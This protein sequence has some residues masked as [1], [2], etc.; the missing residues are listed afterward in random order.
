MRIITQTAGAVA[1]ILTLTVGSAPAADLPR[2]P[3]PVVPSPIAPVR[4]YDWTGPYAGANLGYQW[5]SAA[6]SGA[7][8]SG[9][10]GGFQG[11]YNWQL[12]QFVL[13]VESDLQASAADDLFAAWRFSNPWFGTARGRAGYA[14]NNVMFYA[15][16]GL[17]YGGGTVQIGGLSESHTHV[18]WAGGAG[19]E[20]GLG[21]N[22]S[23]KAEYMFI[24]L[25]NQ[26]YG[27]FGNTG[28]ESSLLRLGANY[29]F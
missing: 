25:G 28:F 11:G 26:R 23:A 16:F 3:S 2:I 5:G 20:V 29:R 12:G 8:P 13:G 24:D 27:L 18:G 10:T 14:M 6:N 21:P 4:A 22:W 17:A 7:N 19:M 9:V 15:S 1:T